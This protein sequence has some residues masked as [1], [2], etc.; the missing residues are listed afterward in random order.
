MGR[1]LC[2]GQSVMMRSWVRP[3]AGAADAG[4]V[5]AS[6]LRRGPAVQLHQIPLRAAPVQPRTAEVMPEPVR[7]GI[8]PALPARWAIIW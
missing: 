6:R 7:P 2:H 8:Y 4:A 3:G 5:T 1:G